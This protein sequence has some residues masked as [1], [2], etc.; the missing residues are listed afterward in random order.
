MKDHENE[1]IEP[2]KNGMVPKH[3]HKEKY[4]RGSFE[5]K[6]W[7][8]L[9]TG[10]V[11]QTRLHSPY[12]RPLRRQTS[13][14]K[15]QDIKKQFTAELTTRLRRRRSSSFTEHG[16]YSDIDEEE[17][18]GIKK[19][20]SIIRLVGVANWDK[21]CI[22]IVTQ[23]LLFVQARDLGALGTCHKAFI[24]PC[25]I[26]ARR[27]A[28]S[29][30]LRA[31]IEKGPGEPWWRTA[32]AAEMCQ[33]GHYSLVAAGGGHELL[34]NDNGLLY[35][36]GRGPCGQ[37]GL[38]PQVFECDNPQLILYARHTNNS[39]RH[40]NLKIQ[41]VAAGAHHSLAIDTSGN[42]WYFGKYRQR[43]FWPCKF[44]FFLA[45]EKKKKILSSIVQPELIIPYVL[46][47]KVVFGH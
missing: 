2:V 3:K 31:I 21:L 30:C 20:T 10:K 4:P 12:L 14:E 18:V 23:L 40:T 19:S 39:S 5:D 8:E 17:S 25:T 42:L 13:S 36:R 7:L 9:D 41:H 29:L 45:A 24:E 26:A 28:R 35:S 27:L 16:D 47:I 11:V 15:R 34:I 33:N 32:R 37:L 22:D 46:I 6:I 38:G 43:I 1:N 44:D